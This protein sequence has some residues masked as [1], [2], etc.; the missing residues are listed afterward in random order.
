MC[1]EAVEAHKNTKLI[2]IFRSYLF[3]V[4]I[5]LSAQPKYAASALW[6]N[7]RESKPTVVQP[8]E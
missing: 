8:A 2:N 5:R 6:N 7:V 1:T 4:S 3:L